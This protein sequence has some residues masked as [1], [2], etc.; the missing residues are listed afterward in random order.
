M[1]EMAC[2][3]ETCPD[4]GKIPP[5]RQKEMK[6]YKHYLEVAKGEVRN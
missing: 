2:Y 1:G 4:C 6:K 3:Q 5:S